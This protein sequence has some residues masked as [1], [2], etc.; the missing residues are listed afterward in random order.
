MKEVIEFFAELFSAKGFIP[1]WVCGDW[2]DFHG[3]LYIISDTLI[4]LAYFAI[5]ILLFYYLIKSSKTSFLPVFWWFIAFIL[6]CGLT[7]IVDVII[8]WYPVYRLSALLK[9]FTA[10][11]SITTVF[12]LIKYLPKAFELKSPEFLELEIKRKTQELSKINNQLLLER[13]KLEI[14]MDASSA[15]LI[16]FNK[17]GRIENVNSQACEIFGYNAGDFEKLAIKDLIPNDYAANHYNMVENYMQKPEQK[18]M[19]MGRE[20]SAKR[21]NGKVIP[22]EIGISPI[23]FG[24]EQMVLA[25]ISNIEI[26]KHKEEQKDQLL[27]DF[28][29]LNR[30]LEHKNSELEDV[31]YIV[32][33]DLRSP[34]HN[35]KGLLNLVAS[36]AGNTK[37][38]LDKFKLQIDRLQ[39]TVDD[40]NKVIQSSQNDVPDSEKV[41]F[42]ESLTKVAESLII[43]IK[44]HQVSIESDF[45]VESI[46]YPKSFVDSYLLNLITNAI[47][48]RK[49][50]VAPE[51]LIRTKL[52]GNKIILSCTD[53]GQGIDL[54]LYNDRLFK[55]GK[56]FHK[57]DDSRGVGLFMIKRQIERLGGHIKVE[58]EVG[59]GTK[60][61]LYLKNQ[62]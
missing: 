39:L 28:K 24:S 18:K 47:K 21:K 15:G 46:H 27:E 10:I 54:N 30:K 59:V 6:F 20:L 14:M 34:I 57:H 42:S 32:S 53:N 44:T 50:N 58:S 61:L 13:M 8:F 40:L 4:W 49:P 45:S 1:R 2:T 29:E 48:Y 11:V 43:D 23:K 9:F 12:V 51:I 5:P 55:F 19:G 25:T 60:F 41:N 52:S 3:W 26:R 33:H 36:D 56:T 16:L 37:E 35:L 62:S 22:V 17:N 31:S 38:Y 7:H